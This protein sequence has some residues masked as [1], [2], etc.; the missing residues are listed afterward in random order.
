MNLSAGVME[1]LCLH[2]VILLLW[3]AEVCYPQ[4]IRPKTLRSKE[5]GVYETLQLSRV[6]E[7]AHE[8]DII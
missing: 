8:F 2:L 1:M 3:L 7:Q 6:Y 5:Y 4:A